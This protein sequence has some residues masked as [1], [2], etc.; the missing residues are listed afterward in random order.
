MMYHF[1]IACVQLQDKSPMHS[2]S[3]QVQVLRKMTNICKKTKDHEK[4]IYLLRCI[5]IYQQCFLLEGDDEIMET[6]AELAD[7]IQAFADN[8]G[9][10]I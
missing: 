4:R 7:A 5:L 10:S 9:S 3:D 1:Y 2:E 6:H 8:G